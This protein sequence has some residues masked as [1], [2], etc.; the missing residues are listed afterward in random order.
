MLEEEEEYDLYYQPSSLVASALEAISPDARLP[1]ELQVQDALWQD[2]ERLLAQEHEQAETLL[3]DEELL[4]NE[5]PQPVEELQQD[6]ALLPNEEQRQDET[7]Y[8][9]EEWQPDALF[10]QE[11][12]LE[13]P[14]AT[15]RAAEVASSPWPEYEPQ[16]QRIDEG[17]FAERPLVEAFDPAV[18]LS[19]VEKLLSQLAAFE[20]SDLDE[21]AETTAIE[22]SADPSVG[23]IDDSDSEA[24]LEALFAQAAREEA[25]AEARAFQAELDQLAALATESQFESDAQDAAFAADVADAEPAVID[26]LVVDELIE[27]PVIHDAPESQNAPEQASLE[28]QSEA[29]PA[30]WQNIDNLAE[31][32]VLFFVV[33]DVTFAVPLAELGGIHRVGHLNNLPGKPPWYLGLQ[34]TKDQQYDVVDTAFW[35]MPDMLKDDE[36]KSKY[37]YIVMLGSSRWGLACNELNGTQSLTPNMVRWREQAGKRPWLAGMVKEKMCALIH[38]EALINMLNAGL[39]VKAMA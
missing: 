22:S 2:E 14:D 37:Q 25:L 29:P 31:F 21:A 35:S 32:Q 39:D 27:E 34:T 24:E 15:E 6:E 17:V 20:E 28:T 18:N 11:Q 26:E 36:Y 33:Q 13:E 8:Q 30:Q 12:L 3:L 1:E 5:E 9:D 19:G 7:L 23:F 38:V 4:Q 10:T 16:L